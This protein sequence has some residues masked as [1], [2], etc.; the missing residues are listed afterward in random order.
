MNIIIFDISYYYINMAISLTVPAY[1]R[2]IKKANDL[3]FE[4]KEKKDTYIEFQIKDLLND[5]LI[6]HNISDQF[7]KLILQYVNIN[8]CIQGKTTLLN[9]L[10]ASIKYCFDRFD[11]KTTYSKIARY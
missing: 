10:N 1:N 4:F 2:I 9:S 5:I 8:D 3:L 11:I 6:I 7:S